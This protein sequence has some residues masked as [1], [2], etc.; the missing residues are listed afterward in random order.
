VLS[1][2]EQTGG[3][4]GWSRERVRI[5]HGPGLQ[6]DLLDAAKRLGVVVVQN[7]LH[8]RGS[9]AQLAEIYDSAALASLAPLRSLVERGIPLAFGADQNGEGMSP[10]LNI[11]VA[12]THPANPKEALTRDQAVI[13]YTRGSAFAENA[14]RE[15]G[16]LAPGMLADLV[17]LSQNIFTV[18]AAALPDTHS[19]LTIIGG[20]VAYDEL[21]S[22]RALPPRDRR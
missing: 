1:L 19:V 2:L 20:K 11:M 9:R 14:E 21:T 7:P 18:P 15:K 17:V 3:A 10:F 8:L 4:S 12:T 22:A 16:T 5:E 6:P 13:A